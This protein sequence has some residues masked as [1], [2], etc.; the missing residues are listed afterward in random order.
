MATRTP[1]SLHDRLSRFEGT[2]SVHERRIF[3]LVLPARIK[4]RVS[5]RMEFLNSPPENILTS[6]EAALL[7]KIESGGDASGKRARQQHLTLIMKAT[8][9]CNL[10]CTYCFSWT[11]G[12]DS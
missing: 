7:R 5:P 1:P 10:R 2:L 3:D 9:S 12:P 4:K 11:S 8:R 6:E